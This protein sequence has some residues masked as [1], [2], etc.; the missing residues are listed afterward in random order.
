[1]SIKTEIARIKDGK[2][3][4][5]NAIIAKDND[6]V[7][8][9]NALINSYPEYVSQIKTGGSIEKTD[10]VAEVKLY[11]NDVLIEDVGGYRIYVNQLDDNSN[12]SFLGVAGETT[13]KLNV[14]TN[15]PYEIMLDYNGQSNYKYN[16]ASSF[17]FSTTTEYTKLMYAYTTEE[18]PSVVA[19]VMKFTITLDDTKITNLS[20]YVLKYT[21][22]LTNISRTLTSSSDIMRMSIATD[23]LFTLSIY[24]KDDPQTINNYYFGWGSDWLYI[25]SNNTFNTHT[26]SLYTK[27]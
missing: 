19:V 23:T 2:L 13:I 26:I 12:T 4:T 7:I 20:D 16:E 5:K 24:K 18:P 15:T 1:M 8:P 21:E 14:K 17:L 27:N 25:P 22:Y 3:Y 6:I 9:D 11:I 10:F